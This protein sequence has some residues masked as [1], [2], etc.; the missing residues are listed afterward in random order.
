MMCI[1]AGWVL[2]RNKLLEEIRKGNKNAEHGWFWKIWPGYVRY[3]CPAAILTVFMHS[4][5]N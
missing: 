4:F 5:L 2:Q 1:F 3:V